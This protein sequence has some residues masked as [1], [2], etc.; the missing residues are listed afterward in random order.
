MAYTNQR[1]FGAIQ[2]VLLLVLAG[3]I[4]GSGYYVYRAQNQKPAAS[5]TKKTIASFAEC[6]A[7]GNPVMESFPEQCAAD[8]QTFTNDEQE[9]NNG[10]NTTATSGLG[11]FEVIFPD[12]MGEIIKPLDSDSFYVMGMEQPE[13]TIGGKTILKELESFGTDAPSLFNIVVHDSF[14]DPR[15]AVEEYTLL[16]GKEN[17]I[18]GKK[19][20]Y[21]YEEDTDEYGIGYQRFKGDRDYEYIFPLPSGK[22]LRVYYSVWGNDPRNNSETIEAIIDTIRLK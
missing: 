16:N 2:L 4:G 10:F 13:F 1:G 19:Y 22:Q 3:L 12:G 11:A 6:V 18:Q 21:I 20:V 17:S 7:A 5:D 14:G 9:V 8:G 15:G